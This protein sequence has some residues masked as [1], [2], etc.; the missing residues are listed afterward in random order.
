MRPGNRASGFTLLEVLVA[1]FIMALVISFAFQ[2]YQGIAEA[3]A[4]VSGVASRGARAVLASRVGFAG[5]RPRRFS[6]STM[7]WGSCL[8]HWHSFW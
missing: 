7:V 1:V 2:A 4:R 6:S 5:L 8:R 3:Y